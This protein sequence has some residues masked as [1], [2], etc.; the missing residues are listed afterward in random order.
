ML[1]RR[2]RAASGLDRSDGI[3]DSMSHRA[4]LAKEA[5]P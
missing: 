5:A 3:F 2:E 1:A 4:L